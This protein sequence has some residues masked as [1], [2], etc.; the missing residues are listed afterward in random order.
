M[1]NRPAPSDI[2]ADARWLAQALDA[3]TGLVR[4]VEMNRKSY[5]AA[6]F[7]DD[8]VL[9]GGTRAVVVPWREV[10][11]AAAGIARRDARWIFHIGHVGSTLVARLLGEIAGV[12]AIREPRI[13]RDV[14][15]VTEER[16]RPLA[17]ALQALLSRTIAPHELALVKATSFVSEIAPELVPAGERALFLFATP[18]AYIEGML[19]G[20]NSRAE[21]PVLAEGRSR[22]MAGRVANLGGS[23]EAHLAAAAWAC[24][25][26]ALEAAAEAMTDREIL[27][28]DFDMMLDDMAGHLA[29]V[30]RF[31]GFEASAERVSEI[32]GGPL[33]SR[34]SKAP[35]FE[36]S[37]TLRR[38]LLDQA[39]SD[40]RGDI[41]SALAML[42]RAAETSPLLQRA[43]A[44]A[45]PES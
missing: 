34:Y 17:E 41:A 5:R 22:R 26:S 12:L 31:F 36:Y 10:E 11:A 18:R 43:L 37:P 42:D 4:L 3:D 38:E 39:A 19:A 14:A 25:M 8:R 24:E 1:S 7:L 20:E 40:F 30:A 33:L 21:L 23:S 28:A 16:R 27:W 35:E 15:L 32:V 2:A 29:K 6:S 45:Q 9:Q 44:R 13:L